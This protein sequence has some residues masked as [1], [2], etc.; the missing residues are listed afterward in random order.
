[1]AGSAWPL[2]FGALH[3]PTYDWHSAHSLLVIGTA[4]LV[5]TAPFLI[6]RNI[7]S[8]YTAHLTNDWSLFALMVVLRKLTAAAALR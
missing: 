5:L 6:T 2:V 3:L 1:M 7:W 4:R 8:S